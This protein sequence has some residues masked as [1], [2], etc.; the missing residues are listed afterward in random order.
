MSLSPQALPAPP[1]LAINGTASVSAASSAAS[2]SAALPGAVTGTVGNGVGGVGG[3]GGD[4]R[5]QGIAGLRNEGNWCYLNASLQVLAR[6]AP[7]RAHLV[8]CVSGPEVAGRP[9]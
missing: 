4:D 6:C 8:E 5:S 7:F 1:G 2:P 3:V 9:W